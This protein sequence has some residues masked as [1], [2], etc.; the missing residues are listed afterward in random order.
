ME[1]E[2]KPQDEMGDEAQ[3]TVKDS[4]LAPL[5]RTES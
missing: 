3:E 2:H 5:E 1:N 4:D